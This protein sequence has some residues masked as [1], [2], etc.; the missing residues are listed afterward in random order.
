MSV[1]WDASH[2]EFLIEDYYYFSKLKR[3][4]EKEGI[5]IYQVNNFNKLDGYDVIV[6]NYPEE[7]FKSWEI[8]KID[9]WLKA[10]K[11]LVFTSYYRNIDSTAENINRVLTK[12]EIPIRI[13]ND[14]V[15][16]PENN[17]GDMMFP[18]ARYNKY[19]VVMP[20]TC[21]ITAQ[22]YALVITSDKAVTHP[23]GLKKP[24][25]GVK[26]KMWGELVVLGTCVFWD[27]HCIEL[28]H[29]KILALDLLQL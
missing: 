1:G 23:T 17:A 4:A 8:K 7:R 3:I 15:I 11:R 25:L 12:L 5:E 24:V 16:D 14:V 21:S 13:N 27:N 18:I 22:N 2:G 19:K 20:C 10:G 29:N 28:E 26:V 9:K 6:F